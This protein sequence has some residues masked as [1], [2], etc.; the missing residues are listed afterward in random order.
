ME[1]TLNVRTTPLDAIIRGKHRAPML[2]ALCIFA[3]ASRLANAQAK[4]TAPPPAHQLAPA[5]APVAPAAPLV[6]KSG[7]D[8]D[9]G[10]LHTTVWRPIGTGV[11]PL[12]IFSHGLHGS[13][14]QSTFLMKAL[15]DHGY[16]VIAPNHRDAY[17]FGKAN[18]GITPPTMGFARAD[19]W[20]DATYRDRAEDIRGMVRKLKSDAAWNKQIDWTKVA[21]IGH[22][23][24]GYTVLGLAGAY[25]SWYLPDAKAVIALSPYCAP[26]TGAK[27]LIRIS[28]PVM[29][30][31]GTSDY[32]ITPLLKIKGGAFDQTPSPVV[33][34]DFLRA[35]HFAWTDMNP[36]FQPDI[37]G[38]CIA[39]LDKYLNGNQHTDLLTKTAHVAEIRSK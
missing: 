14:R 28:I 10:T 2:V 39:F 6:P 23:L 31:G 29:Y 25:G 5:I 3:G 19:R 35:N 9:I 26:L 22:S 34:V 13:S 11:H 18:V 36:T 32:G 7:E 17:R 15:S 21:L 20:T 1:Y 37:S 8:L 24:G 16:L 30:Q 12:V 33:F 27:T 38:Y 4:P